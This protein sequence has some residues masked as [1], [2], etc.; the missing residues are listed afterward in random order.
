MQIRYIRNVDGTLNFD[1]MVAEVDGG[2]V[3]VTI[4]KHEKG[5]AATS[6]LTVQGARQLAVFLERAACHAELSMPE[7]VVG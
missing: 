6:Y 1:V 2:F 4:I 3:E 5:P 7:K